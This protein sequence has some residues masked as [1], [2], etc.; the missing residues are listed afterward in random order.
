FHL[1]LKFLGDVPI[2]KTLQIESVLLDI[3]PNHKDFQIMLQGIGA[4]PNISDP[5]VIWAGIRDEN[6]LLVKIWS[7]LESGLDKLGFSREKRGFSPHLTLGRVK[8]P[9]A[10]LTDMIQPL[11]NFN[12]TV[13]VKEIKLMS[14]RLSRNGPEYSC[15]NSFILQEHLT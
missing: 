13:P 14:S 15:I 2:D 9:T 11:Q 3:C 5:R 7:E 4:F 6:K 12:I 1:T 10:G 8:E